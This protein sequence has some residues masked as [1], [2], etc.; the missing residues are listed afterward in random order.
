MAF[1][2]N[3]PPLSGFPGGKALLLGSLG[4]R[5]VVIGAG[6]PRR[7]SDDLLNVAQALRRISGQQSSVAQTGIETQGSGAQR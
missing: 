5:N 7:S 3:W 2:T 1:K 4:I 6:D